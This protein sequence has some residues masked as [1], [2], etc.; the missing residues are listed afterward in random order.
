MN[1]TSKPAVSLDRLHQFAAYLEQ[2]I[3][4]GH[5]DP[6]MQR[7]MEAEL[8]GNSQRLPRADIWRIMQRLLAGSPHTINQAELEALDALQG[9][10]DLYSTLRSIVLATHQKTGALTGRVGVHT[11]I[12]AETDAN[13][14][15]NTEALMRVLAH[16]QPGNRMIVMDTVKANADEGQLR[17]PDIFEAQAYGQLRNGLI[18]NHAWNLQRLVRAIRDRGYQ[19]RTILMIRLDGPDS[20]ANVNPFNPT[21]LQKYQLAIA[22]LIRYLET[23]LPLT[24]FKL[25]LGNE[26]DLP[27]ERQWSDSNVDARLFTLNQFAPATGTFMKRIARQ[28]PDVTFLCPAL[29]ANLKHDNLGYYTAFFGEERLENLIPAMHGYAADVAT[30]PAGQKNLLEQQAEALRVLGKFRHVS[31]TEIGSGNP[32]GD[33][34]NLSEKGRFDEVVAWLLLSRDHRAPPGQDNHWNFQINPAA[35]DPM[36]RHL[37]DVINRSKNRV[38]RN[39]RERNGAGLQ[40]MRAQPVDRPAYGV[41]YLGHNTPTTTIAGQTNA[42]NIAIRNTSYRTWAAGGPYPVRMGYHWYLPDGREVAPTLWDDNRTHL[43]YDIPPGESASLNC[44]L[45]IPRAPGVYD[46]RWDL[47][48]EQRTWFAWQGVSTLNVRVTVKKEEEDGGSTT[49]P[50]GLRVSAS[51]N[52]QQQGEENLLQAIDN[53][54]YTRWST[55][56]PQQPGMWFQIDL[57]EVRTIRQVRLNND[58]SPR[59]YPRGYAVKLSVD[60]QNWTTVAENPLNDQPLNV[61]FS[62]RQARYIHIDQTGQDSVFWWSIHEID[63]ASEIKL[64][65]SASHNNVLVGPDNVAQALD[66]RPD[67][68]WSSRAVQQPGMWFELDLNQTRTVSGLTLDSSRSSQDYPRGYVVRISTDRQQWE[69][70][71]RRDQNDQGLNVSF[72]PRPARYIR[73]EQTGSADRWW[74]SINEVVVKSSE[75]APSPTASAS[76]NNVSVGAD[77]VSQAFDGRPDTRWSSRA[78]Q[79][80][81]MWFEID[82]NQTR[83]VS[84]LTLDT[85]QSSQDYPRGYVVRISTNRQQ[86][87]EVARRDQNDRALDVSFNPRPARYI[88]IEQTGSSDQWWW[89]INEVRVK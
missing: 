57:G 47:V 69:E 34:E 3:A 22:K 8:R 80:P 19:D 68:R 24:P 75:V 1:G 83:T 41:E 42:V 63:I 81:G 21:S 52:N 30:L 54:P 55:R 65:A 82:L 79:Q 25:V 35:D 9:P 43:P 17:A 32:F 23:V 14:A 37:G 18:E 7:Q 16:V 71:A 59:D 60:R 70:V 85:T 73:V 78:V 12:S 20:G 26:P 74:W 61:S 49:P 28:R 38:L 89:S 46:V 39:I 66:G 36:A 77:N 88:R 51:H 53:N 40:I 5:S 29:S 67:T 33:T 31:G 56:Q 11:R 45:S 64:T 10:K 15:T 27:Q 13:A 4:F 58:P 48:E 86:W 84:G 44:N 2:N 62:P 6:A 87:E 50:T 76:H 72:N